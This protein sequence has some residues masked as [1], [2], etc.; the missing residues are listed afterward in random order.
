[1]FYS[2]EGLR[3]STVFGVVKWTRYHIFI[4]YLLMAEATGKKGQKSGDRYLVRGRKSREL[5]NG[6]ARRS[7]GRV[8]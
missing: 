2:H 4:I 1:M 6:R 3:L 5:A 7:V 8:G